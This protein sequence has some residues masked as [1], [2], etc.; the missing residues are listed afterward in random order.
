MQ[1]NSG[2][3]S[4]VSVTRF[5][6]NDP[7][8]SARQQYTTTE[9]KEAINLGYFDV[10]NLILES[11]PGYFVTRTYN[12][13][14]VNQTTITLPSDFTRMI[15]VAVEEGGKNLSSDT[16]ADGRLYEAVS[17]RKLQIESRAGTSARVWAPSPSTAS[18]G[19]VEIHPKVLIAGT[20][21]SSFVY[22]YEPTA[23]S[24]NTDA[25]LFPSTHHE[26]IAVKGAIYLKN[27]RDLDT[28]ALERRERALTER[29][30]ANISTMDIGT[31]AQ[32]GSAAFD[33]Q[34]IHA[35]N[36]GQVK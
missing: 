9:T 8:T 35:S 1:L 17:W 2:S 27:A 28:R 7:T 4:L 23:L 25:P 34:Y 22:E 20:S 31:T 13:T 36:V 6:V 3:P 30:K 19:K 10:C 29:L 12:N 14:S 15:E 24:G 18:A 11:S 21:A 5:Y 16:T 26:L 32:F 33:S